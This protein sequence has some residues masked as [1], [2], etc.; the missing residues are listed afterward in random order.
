MNFASIDARM[1][2]LDFWKIRSSTLLIRRRQLF[3]AKEHWCRTICSLRSATVNPALTRPNL[4]GT[5]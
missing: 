3:N 5:A 4:R 2:Q 1:Y